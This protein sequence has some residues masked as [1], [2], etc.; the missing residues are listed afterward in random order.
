MVVSI[1]DKTISVESSPEPTLY[2]I[3]QD[4]GWSLANAF[5]FTWLG[6]GKYEGATNFSTNATFRLFDKADWP[7][8]FGNYPYFEEGEISPLL[9]DANDNDLNFRFVGTTGT[10]TMDVDLYNLNVGMNQ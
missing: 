8:G 5:K 6:G 3:G 7:N 1:N 4:Q 9:E 2:I 10:F